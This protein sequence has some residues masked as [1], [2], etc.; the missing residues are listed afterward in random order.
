[1][2]DLLDRFLL[3]LAHEK[4]CS[5][6]TLDAYTRDL[7]Q[8][9]AFL[10]EN[11]G[12]DVA[13]VD[14]MAMRKYLAFLRAKDYSRST[15]ARKLVSLRSFY[16]FLIR[17]GIVEENPTRAV[18]TPKL[19]K[20][21]PRFLD[22]GEVEKLLNMPR[23]LPLPPFVKL[24]DI[25]ILETLY[26]T[27]MRVGE[28]GALDLSDVDFFS[29]RVVAR[30]KGKKERYAWLGGP[31]LAALKEYMEARE[32]MAAAGKI[33]TEA[34]FVNLRGGRLTTRSIERSLGRYASLA[35][36]GTD[37]TPHT[38]RHSFATHLLDRGADLRVVQE[39]LG[40]ENL[41][42][43]QIYTH[44]TTERLKEVYNRAHPRA[45]MA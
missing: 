45:R 12:R 36:L 30:G 6:H 7:Q 32:L 40:H 28:I 31:S 3:R 4:N 1:M 33:R 13:S 43:T 34:L 26:S 22:A 29:E 16:K 27:G 23:D 21:L 15:T 35:G 11:G 2:Q 42:T 41:S 37:V 25:A 18:R 14:R 38:L 9:A 10:R 5:E 24:R 19:E 8:F 20:K 17:E 44:L 39:M